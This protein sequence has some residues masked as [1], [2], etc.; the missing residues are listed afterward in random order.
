[1]FAKLWTLLHLFTAFSFVGTLLVAEWIGRSVR[2]TADWPQ[3]AMLFQ[4]AVRAGRSAGFV[5]LVLSGVFGNAT[6]LTSGYRMATD[7]WLVWANAMW[8]VAVLVMAALNLPAAY[9]LATLARSAGG[10]GEPAG[11][12]AT[13]GRWRIS[14]VV[15]SVLYLALLV[16]MVY[17]A[18]S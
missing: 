15:L 17:G 18:R 6:A 11:Y 8:L 16:V 9:R 12:A 1:M 3:R 7:P 10:G 2:A 14:N 5:P 13:L 4:I